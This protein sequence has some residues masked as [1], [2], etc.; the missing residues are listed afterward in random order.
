MEGFM[1]RFYIIISVILMVCPV[2]ISQEGLGLEPLPNGLA[3]ALSQAQPKGIVAGSQAAPGDG[4]TVRNLPSRVDLSPYL[5]PVQSQGQI[6]SCS[7]W[8]TVYYAKTLQE[9]QERKWDPNLESHQYSP[10]FTYNQITKGVNRG[11]S[12]VSHM[13]LLEQQGAATFRTFPSTRDIAVFPGNNAMEEAVLYKSASHRKLD[14]YD[15]VR[16]TWYV[17]LQS[18]KTALAEGLPVIGGFEAYQNLYEYQGG[19]YSRADGPKRG[20]HAMCIVGYDDEKRALR[21][22]NSWGTDWGERGFMWMA[23]DL[24]ESLCVYNAAVMYDV[25]E[26]VP[27][28]ITPPVN[29]NVTKGA[30]DNR[31]SLAWT[32]VTDAQY[33]MI[34]RVNNEEGELKEIGR[35]EAPA[36]NDADLPPG[37]SY[38]YAVKSGKTGRSGQIISGFSEIG[39]G[40]TSEEKTPPGIPGNLTYQMAEN[41]P[42]LNWDSVDDARGYNI[43]RWSNSREEF[44]KTGTSRDNSFMDTRFDQAE[45][46]IVYYLVEA[47]N[48]Y[49][50]G[51][52]SDALSVLKEL[53]LPEPPP[54]EKINPVIIKEKSQD[55]KP[56]VEKESFEGEYYRTDYFD[57]AYTQARFREF[58]EKE[59]EAFKNFKEEELSAFELWKKQNGY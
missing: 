52:S 6:G 46:G 36:Y 28:N 20:G 30:H 19:I 7:A 58:Y 26:P 44:M 29:L 8:S 25:V 22:V 27:E 35:T 14:K 13:T 49:G 54:E 15:E 50:S 37:V 4:K 16:R 18:V 23:Y 42:L 24:F 34:F 3:R 10:L 45:P 47:Y 11:T 9:N 32:P 21:I 33:Y 57:F 51:Y 17:D 12:I 55:D 38:V 59:Q 40:W 53:I 39:E 48:Q 56:I 5:P 1:K 2:L 41:L 31:I 43:Y